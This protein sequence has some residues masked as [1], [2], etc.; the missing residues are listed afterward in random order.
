MRG[1]ISEHI[2][3]A[4]SLDRLVQGYLITL[5]SEGKSPHSVTYYHQMLKNFLW[6]CQQEGIPRDA[7]H[8]T[9]AHIRSF[10]LYV[11]NEP[12]RW[13]GKA[14]SSRRPASATTVAHYY[15]ALRTFYNWVVGEGLVG[16]NPID[17]VRPPKVP[18][19]VIQSFG[20]EELKRMLDLCGG[21]TF[22]GARNRAILILFVD[23][24]LRLSELASL[25]VSDIDFARGTILVRQGKGQKQRI[26]HMGNRCQKAIWRWVILFRENS[27]DRLFTSCEGEPVEARGI[28]SL[29]KRLC[30]GAGITGGRGCHRLRHTFA[31]EFLRA[32]GDLMSLRYLLGHSS[33][34]MVK[35]YLG[36]LTAEDA[37]RAHERFSPADSMSLR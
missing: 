35:R 6:W 34:E 5:S 33:L 7:E 30:R 31:I 18:E 23:T 17:T 24:G 1:G 15:G 13:G 2:V 8:I 26:V 21:K 25:K 10:L 22:L 16:G 3:G 36:S 12:V 9:S 20:R 37:A 19:K 28:Q 4:P 29:I 32:G 14:A 27:A 11:R